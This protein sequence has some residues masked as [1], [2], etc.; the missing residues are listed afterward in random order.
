MQEFLCYC[1]FLPT[2]VVSTPITYHKYT[3][4]INKSAHFNSIPFVDSLKMILRDFTVAVGCASIYFLGVVNFPVSYLSAPS[5][6][7]NSFL[8]ILG[9]AQLSIY[10]Y[11]WKYFFAFKLC[12]LPIHGS[13]VSYN[14]ELDNPFSGVQT[15]NIWEFNTTLSLPN[16]INSWNIPVQEW[17]RKAVYER[18]S[19]SREKAKLITFL[20]SSFW[21][22]FYG[23]YYFAF[24]LFFLH[25]YV[26]TSIYKLGRSSEQHPLIV[27]YSRWLPFSRYLVLLLLTLSFSHSGIYFAVLSTQHCLDLLQAFYYLPFVLLTTLIFVLG[28]QVP[29]AVKKNA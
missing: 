3:L 11:H 17:L 1:L 29:G 8:Y 2:C 14:P 16:K 25:M 15:V 12:M 28:R 4:Y 27:I 23:G 13:G 26:G 7:D 5:F 24:A 10:F 18:L 9:Y 19:T 20:V 21:H 6:T 22:G